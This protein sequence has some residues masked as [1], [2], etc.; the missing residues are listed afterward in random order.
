MSAE[1]CISVTEDEYYDD[2]VDDINYYDE[3]EI[4]TDCY[5]NS[6]ES[7]GSDWEDYYE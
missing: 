5:D 4:S 3:D 2:L 1:D 6:T 7:D